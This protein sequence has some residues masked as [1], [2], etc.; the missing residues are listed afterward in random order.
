MFRLKKEEWETLRFQA[1]TSTTGI[2]AR[3]CNRAAPGLSAYPERLHV[4]P[5]TAIRWT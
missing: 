3:L 1:G 4:A 2:N 5:S